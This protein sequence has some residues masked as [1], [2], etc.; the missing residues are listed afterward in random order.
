MHSALKNLQNKQIYIFG[1]GREGLSTYHFL[2]TIF[3]TKKLIIFDDKPIEKIDPRL[4]RT[5]APDKFTSLIETK[6]L[7]ATLNNYHAGD[8]IIFKTP[9]VPPAHPIFEA[10][11]NQRISIN[12]NTNLFLELTRGEIATIGVTGTKGKSTTSSI[13]YHLLKNAG[14]RVVLGG[15]IGLPPLDLL[16]KPASGEAIATTAPVAN[17]STAATSTK[18]TAAS[19][20]EITPNFD[21]CVLELSDHQLL[22][23][24]HS[25]SIAVVLDISPEHLD[26]YENFQS[27]VAAKAN[28]AKFQNKNDYI[29]YNPNFKYPTEIA[30]SSKAKEITFGT[31]RIGTKSKSSATPRPVLND[32]KPENYS[33]NSELQA[34]ILDTDIYL[35]G[36]KLVNQSDLH[37]RGDH[38]LLN[39][40]PSI[41]IANLLDIDNESIKNGLISFAPLAHRLE[42]VAEINGIT[43]INDSLSTT[44]VATIAAIKTFEGKPLVL[45]AGGH[46][47]KQDFTD[48]AKT[49][50]EHDVRA[51]LYFNPTGE[52]LAAAVKNPNTIKK[53]VFTMEEAV[54]L[55]AELAGSDW[56][57]L[58]S[59]GSAS[60]GTFRDYEER[61]DRF[62]ESV[63]TLLPH[64]VPK[65]FLK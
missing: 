26:Y 55:A 30:R 11:A 50:D 44:P 49:M 35:K 40:L 32:S 52:R 61:G 47:R 60:F 43:F 34:Y 64:L 12:S 41:I 57:V 56:V 23:V 33:P 65:T 8:G 1:L 13:I 22:D 25:P 48:L 24:K 62:K 28:I 37:L 4:L 19:S 45:I 63:L 6:A 10:I 39:C 15:N 54:G 3:P 21:Y 42:T 7:I 2:R 31:K 51:L 53:E 59:P 36:K 27:Y 38:N 14:L 20:T 9:G 58:M 17:H 16:R 5:I 29:I 18:T 46:E